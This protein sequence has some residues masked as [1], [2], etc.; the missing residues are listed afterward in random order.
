MGWYFLAAVDGEG[1]RGGWIPFC[2]DL[3]FVCG[4]RAETTGIGV[5]DFK[6]M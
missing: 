6:C 4:E 3:A 1:V 5:I 2:I